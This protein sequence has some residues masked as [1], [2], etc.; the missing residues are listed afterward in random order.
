M[1]IMG[2]KHILRNSW[3]ET[4]EKNKQLLKQYGM[5]NKLGMPSNDFSN[6]LR[7]KN[8]SFTKDLI[9]VDL[10][11]EYNQGLNSKSI[12]N[13]SSSLNLKNNQYIDSKITKQ[14]QNNVKN[15]I[16]ENEKLALEL[17]NNGDIKGAIK[18]YEENI[19]SGKYCRNSYRELFYVYSS[20]DED[21]KAINILKRQIA[22]CEDLN[23]DDLDYLNEELKN[24]KMRKST[25]RIAK[26]NQKIKYLE[27]QGMYDEL[28]PLHIANLNE[29]DEFDDYIL[30]FNVLGLSRIY[31][32]KQEFQKEFDVLNE[33][34]ERLKLKENIN[35]DIL[36][37]ILENLEN[38]RS[39]L[40][41]G[42][43]KKDCLPSDSKQ[44]YLKIKEAKRILKEDDEEIGIQL[45]ENI[46]SEDP[47]NNTVYYTLYKTY[48]ANKRYDDAIRVCN[49]AIDVLGLFSQDRIVK[50]TGYLEMIPTYKKP[51]NDSKQDTSNKNEIVDVKNDSKEYDVISTKFCLKCNTEINE[52]LNVCP[53]CKYDFI[54]NQYIFEDKSY[55]NNPSFVK[56]PQKELIIL[57][58]DVKKISSSK[59]AKFEYNSKELFVE[60]VA[61]EYYEL[62]GYSSIWSENDYWSMVY[63]LLFWDVI[64]LRNEKIMKMH[65]QYYHPDADLSNGIPGIMSGTSTSPTFYHSRS[66]EIDNKIKELLISDIPLN[67]RESYYEHYGVETRFIRNWDKFSLDQ[68]TIPLELLTNEQIILIMDRLLHDY[69]YNWS[70][71]P[72]VIVFDE[73]ELIFVEVKSKNDNLSDG[74]IEWHEYL[75]NTV[76]LKVVLFTVNKTDRQ[77]KNLVKKYE[78]IPRK[79]YTMKLPYK[80]ESYAKTNPKL[81][82]DEEL[83]KKQEENKIL[84]GK[85]ERLRKNKDAMKLHEFNVKTNAPF[86][87][88]YIR[89]A[90]QHSNKKDY[91]N[92]IDICKKGLGN[93]TSDKDKQLLKT[94]LGIYEKEK[95]KFIENKNQSN[96]SSPTSSLKADFLKKNKIKSSKNLFCINCG[97]KLDR[98]SNFCHNCGSKVEK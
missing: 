15:K 40:E 32:Y 81:L 48:M 61:M 9:S 71:F 23:C 70:G 90:T 3:N 7:L 31:H 60:E 24:F 20:N 39:Y 16:N 36:R 46:M 4:H 18:L 73:N 57:N 11:E 22:K 33:G 5:L 17:R 56:I 30:P 35:E 44:T 85:L 87:M 50:Y 96:S 91:D 79:S 51:L 88:S 26:N 69:N 21:E 6:F 72:D 80:Q 95:R 67:I 68:L 34:Y 19:G 38:V 84:A 64:F 86:A 27:E 89:I 83:L 63:V 94:Y 78:N 92:A 14:K 55:L 74:Q 66:N 82:N 8:M 1:I 47:Y 2:L 37:S 29:I 53:N 75:L 45:L 12:K 98:D 76:K 25:S 54:N 28:I 65:Y 43:F 13:D 49:K 59:K 58:K 41:T 42:K 77:L 93:V 62:K 10:I 52:S 97:I